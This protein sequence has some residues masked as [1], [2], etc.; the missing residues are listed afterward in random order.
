LATGPAKYYMVTVGMNWK[1]AKWPMFRP[2]VRYDWPE[3]VDAYD[4]RNK[5][6]QLIFGADAVVTF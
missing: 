4:E 3:G 2:E 6:H 1:P 5:D